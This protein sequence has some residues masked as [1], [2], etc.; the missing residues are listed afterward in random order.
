M[1][2]WHFEEVIPPDE[3]VDATRGWIASG[4]RI[5]GACC[6]LGIEHIRALAD[7]IGA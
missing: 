7:A 2:H 1:P 4:V 5:V 6:G 3:F